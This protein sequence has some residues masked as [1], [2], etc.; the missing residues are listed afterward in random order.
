MAIVK[1]DECGAS[2]ITIGA[3]L[4]VTLTYVVLALWPLGTDCCLSGSKLEESDFPVAKLD[5]EVRLGVL[6]GG[7]L[8]WG[9]ALLQSLPRDNLA[10]FYAN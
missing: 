2:E 10:N 6:F 7:G 9:L 3:A 5:G 4:A 8:S 1:D